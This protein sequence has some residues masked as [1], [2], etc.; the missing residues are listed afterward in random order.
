MKINFLSKQICLLLLTMILATTGCTSREAVEQNPRQKEK[1]N[2]A[3]HQELEQQEEQPEDGSDEEPIDMDTTFDDELLEDKTFDDETSEKDL[4]RNQKSSD[5]Q[6]DQ[7]KKKE[8]ANTINYME[9]DSKF[10]E[11][12][13]IVNPLILSN[14]LTQEFSPEQSPK[15]GNGVW[16]SLLLSLDEKTASQY[17]GEDFP[18]ELVEDTIT[19]V[20]PVTKE[21]IREN[22]QEYSAETKTYAQPEGLGGHTPTFR[23]SGAQEK[24]DMLVLVVD[25]Y[26]ADHDVFNTSILTIQL[27]KNDDD[28]ITSWDYLSNQ[29]MFER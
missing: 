23:I 12:G 3:L 27:E 7:S 14:I 16:Y 8:S 24:D 2:E 1:Q 5:N 26:D 13:E 19:T 10:Q 9:E 17:E 4:S 15:F 28:K 25:L 29:I 20:F 18:R 21:Q 6:L 11:Y 22:N